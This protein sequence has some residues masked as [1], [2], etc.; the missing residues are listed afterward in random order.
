MSAYHFRFVTQFSKQLKRLS[1]RNRQLKENFGEFLEEL[2]VD[3]TLH[4]IIPKTGGARKARMRVSGRGKSGGYRVIYYIEIE[5]YIWLLS[6]YDKVQQ[7]DLSSSELDDIANYVKS[8]KEG[9]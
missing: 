2:S 6:I 5:E 3:P 9:S 8:I 4:P 7:E 1:K